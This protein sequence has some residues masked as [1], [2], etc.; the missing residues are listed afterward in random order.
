MGKAWLSVLI[1]AWTRMIVAWVVTF[2]APS[3]RTCMALI[4]SCIERYGRIP[5]TIVV[6]KGPEFQSIYLE[7]LLARLEC[8][9]KPRPGSKPRF[10]SIIE[11]FLVL[12][13]LFVG[14][15]S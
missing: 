13:N 6:D 8:H 11:R 14:A 5:K 9:K 7:M 15:Y 2:D 10:G 1:D 3:Y 4:R 12:Y